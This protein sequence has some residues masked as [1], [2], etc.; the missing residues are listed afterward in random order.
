MDLIPIC[1]E[2]LEKNNKRKLNM[3][4]VSFRKMFFKLQKDKRNSLVLG[5]FPSRKCVACSFRADY[6][7]FT[8]IY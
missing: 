5:V 7:L 8:P 3:S 1:K 2:K 4:E 6:T